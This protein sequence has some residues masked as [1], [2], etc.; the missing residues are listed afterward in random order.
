M[1]MFVLSGRLTADPESKSDNVTRY[2]LAVDNPFGK[3]SKVDFLD[4]VA[5]GKEAEFA[6][7][8]LHKGSKI[9]VNGKI[10]KSVYTDKTGKKVYTL[11][12]IVDH[13]EFCESKKSEESNSGK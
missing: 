1:N 10:K 6:K 9:L 11:D 5:F 4:C 8:Y 3:E 7:K 13:H 2:C 12:L